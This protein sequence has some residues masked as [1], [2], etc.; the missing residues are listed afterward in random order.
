[1]Q[2]ISV[3][4]ERAGQPALG[5][6]FG[7]STWRP[8]RTPTET[9]TSRSPSTAGSTFTPSDTSTVETENSSSGS[10]RY[11]IRPPIAQERLE[12]LRDGRLELCSKRPWK[13]DTRAGALR[14]VV[15]N[16][17]LE[18]VAFLAIE[19]P[20]A[21]DREAFPFATRR[22]SVTRAT[23]PLSPKNVVRGQYKGYRDEDGVA[24]D[25]CVET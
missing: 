21:G 17:L 14:D 5:L 25:S 13:D 4:G 15:Q 8:S 1:M 6:V 23:R 20:P 19:P 16:H 9:S 3:V 10:R 24:K 2:G 22:R 11:I 18:V 7:T 12:R